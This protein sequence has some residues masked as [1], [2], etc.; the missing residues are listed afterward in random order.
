MLRPIPRRI[1]Q[2]TATVEVCRAVDRYH[3][4]V[5][6]TFEAY[7]VHLQPSN[8]IRKNL[9]DTDFVLEGILF[10]DAR[11][12]SPSVNW[13]ELFE[14]ANDN[15]GDMKITVRGKTYIVKTAEALRDD[16][17]RLHHWELGLV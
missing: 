9:S 16:T 1:L 14:T 17:D 3:N 4:Q 10:V 7:H 2:T 11:I 13:T 12:S 8:E 5:Y 15:G 6:D